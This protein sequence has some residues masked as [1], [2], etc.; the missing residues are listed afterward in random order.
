MSHN[1]RDDIQQSLKIIANELAI[2]FEIHKNYCA[3]TA[4]IVTLFIIGLLNESDDPRRLLA[5]L[6]AIDSAVTEAWARIAEIADEEKDVRYTVI[7]GGDNGRWHA[8]LSDAVGVV[9]TIV[10]ERL[11]A[12]YIGRTNHIYAVMKNEAHDSEYADN[13][14]CG[15]CGAMLTGF[16]IPREHFGRCSQY[17]DSDK[18]PA[19]PVV[20][21]SPERRAYIEERLIENFKLV[22]PGFAFRFGVRALNSKSD[23]EVLDEYKEDIREEERCE[24]VAKVRQRA[25][26]AGATE[27]AV[28]FFNPPINDGLGLIIRVYNHAQRQHP[29]LFGDMGYS[30][31]IEGHLVTVTNDGLGRNLGPVTPPEEDGDGFDEESDEESE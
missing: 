17:T 9:E 24:A 16:G 4:E 7:N 2:E 6:A 5:E 18:P 21:I 15:E 28:Y 30:Q 11:N 19:K 13:D 8:K 27:V 10:D 12:D 23:E 22:D 29:R 20:A 3:K 14:P 31:F 26:L 1:K 25:D